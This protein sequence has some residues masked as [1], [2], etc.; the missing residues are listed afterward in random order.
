MSQFLIA[1]LLL[2][3]LNMFATSRVDSLIRSVG[4]QGLLV[5]CLVALYPEGGFSWGGWVFLAVTGLI[6]AII[7][8]A[9]MFKALKSVGIRRELEPMVGYRKSLFIGLIAIGFSFWVSVKLPLPS[10]VLEPA[11]TVALLSMIAGLFLV[12]SRKKAISQAIG[13]L[14]MENGIY[15]LGPALA[16]HSPLIV[17]AG[18]LLDLFVGVFVMGVIIL[19]IRREFNHI[20]VDRLSELKD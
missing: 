1:L 17:E 10:G 8:P 12:V 15:V 7:L 20:D 2:V 3:N 11:L 14:V 6:K 18:V 13:Y 19:H 5:V 16:I 4:V 9:V